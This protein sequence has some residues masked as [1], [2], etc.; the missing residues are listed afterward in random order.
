MTDFAL[1]D[2]AEFLGLRPLFA[3]LSASWLPAAQIAKA[4]PNRRREE[5][6]L[7]D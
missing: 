2:G 4:S 1:K 3:L 6:I 5:S 7:L